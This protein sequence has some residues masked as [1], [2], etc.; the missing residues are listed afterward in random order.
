[1]NKPVLLATAGFFFIQELSIWVDIL[2]VVA[3][4]NDD[5][6]FCFLHV[7]FRNRF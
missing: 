4:D 2:D 5:Y 6:K 1:M 7:A 3:I